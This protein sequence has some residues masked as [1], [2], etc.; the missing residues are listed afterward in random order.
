MTATEIAQLANVGGY[1]VNGDAGSVASGAV[2]TITI[3][4]MVWTTPAASDGSFAVL[5]SASA[6]DTVTITTDLGR[7]ET[8]TAQ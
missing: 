8:L 2:V 5:V 6:G 4:S 7:S 3:N 1:T